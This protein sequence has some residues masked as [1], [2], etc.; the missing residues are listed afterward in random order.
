MMCCDRTR[1]RS[2][3]ERSEALELTSFVSARRGS[4]RNGQRPCIAGLGLPCVT[5]VLDR[6]VAAHREHTGIAMQ[7][8]RTNKVLVSAWPAIALHDTQCEAADAG[9]SP[10][11]QAPPGHGLAGGVAPERRT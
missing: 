11:A 4:I 7:R 2:A 5:R 6:W 9:P 10:L 8:A 1:D 3:S